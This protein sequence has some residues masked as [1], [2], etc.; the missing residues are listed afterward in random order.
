MGFAT[1]YT[2]TSFFLIS[3]STYASVVLSMSKRKVLA[4][5]KI[6]SASS[7]CISVVCPLVALAIAPQ[8]P[9]GQYCKFPRFI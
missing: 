3:Y 7:V 6:F 1:L 8:G 2:V 4:K 9:G 5:L